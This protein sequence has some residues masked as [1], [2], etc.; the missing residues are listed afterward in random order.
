MNRRRRLIAEEKEEIIRI[1]QA[2]F[3]GFDEIEVG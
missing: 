1:I 2:T 3:A